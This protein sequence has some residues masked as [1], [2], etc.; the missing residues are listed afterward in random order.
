M[1]H[2]IHSIIT[3]HNGRGPKHLTIDQPKGKP[4]VAFQ[5]RQ[6]YFQVEDRI[7]EKA[8]TPFRKHLITLFVQKF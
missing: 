2:I 4:I 7:A 8:I 5:C 3:W 1:L 6:N